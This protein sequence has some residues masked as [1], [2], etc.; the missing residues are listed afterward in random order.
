MPANWLHLESA[1][2]FDRVNFLKAGLTQAQAITTVSPTYAREILTPEY[3]CGLEGLLLKRYNDLTGIL[4]GV[5]PEEWNPESDPALPARFSAGDTAGKARCKAA[6]QRE[7][8]LPEDPECPL[9]AN[10]SRL[11]DQKGSALIVEAVRNLLTA[12]ES[13]Q[14]AILGSGERV[15]E[16]AFRDLAKRFPDR[17]AARDQ[18]PR[19]ADRN[20][21]AQG[22]RAGLGQHATLA[23]SAK[24]EV[25]GL[26]DLS[27]GRSVVH[28]G[29]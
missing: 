18:P 23:E 12:G 29:Q 26:L 1:L 3:G 19:H 24:A 16:N 22:S 27:E 13:L 15:L 7:L 6:L 10:I 11:T 2:H 8:G 20:A 14:L 17:V 4:N 25:L 28:F 5:D 21:A 9:F